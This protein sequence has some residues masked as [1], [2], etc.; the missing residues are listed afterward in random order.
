MKNVIGP[1]CLALLPALLLGTPCAGQDV[2][3]PFTWA[4]DGTVTLI[5]LEGNGTEQSDFHFEFSVDGRGAVRGKAI[6]EDANV[7]VKQVFYSDRLETAL[8][9]YF[10][11]NIAIVSVLNEFGRNPLMYILSGRVLMDKYFYGEVMIARY[12]SGSP[13]AEA[14]GVDTP[15]AR[16]MVDGELPSDVKSA[17]DETPPFGSAIIVGDY[18]PEPAA[19]PE[20]GETVRL[21]NGNDF[22]GWFMWSEEE[23]SDPADVWLV[24]DGT[25]W[26]TGEA[27]GFLRTAEKYGNYKLTLE[28][29]WAG[30]PG[31]SGVL[32]HMTDEEKVWPLS[33]EAQVMHGK[34]GDLI[35][36]GCRFTKDGESVRYSPRADE[37]IEKEPGEWNSY[38][39]VCHQDT[40]ELN[41]NGKTQNKGAGIPLKE[42]Y[43][44]F[45]SEGAPIQFRN[46]ELTPLR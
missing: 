7:I 26:C 39:I 31:N 46:I 19:E 33:M 14:L 12:E 8:P 25:I 5:N 35:G 38:E 2:Q 36:M 3:P 20:K 21:F 44:G 34:A 15:R 42:G 29:R 28:W 40:M 11:R 1:M 16:R 43:I 32:L 6:N 22:D 30:G 37:T 24:K 10:T 27:Q 9:K 18:V 45:Q 13:L 17:L 23:D 4:G 41:V